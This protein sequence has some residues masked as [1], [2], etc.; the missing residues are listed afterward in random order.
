LI[1]R[2]KVPLLIDPASIEITKTM[3]ALHPSSILLLPRV[4]QVSGGVGKVDLETG[5][6]FVVSAND[7]IPESLRR[8]LRLVAGEG[9]RTLFRTLTTNQPVASEINA[10]FLRETQAV[11]VVEPNY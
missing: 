4:V 3:V 9:L 5:L 1:G 7:Q 8:T 2:R 11:I 6:P 10:S